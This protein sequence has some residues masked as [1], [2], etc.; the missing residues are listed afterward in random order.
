[1]RQTATRIIPTILLPIN[2]ISSI[3]IAIQNR[4]SPRTRLTPFLPKLFMTVY[5][6]N[7]F[8]IIFLIPPLSEMRYPVLRHPAYL[9][10]RPFLT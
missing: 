2:I 10:F 9:L 5:A 7:L 6:Q 3:P 8:T 1:M 4:I